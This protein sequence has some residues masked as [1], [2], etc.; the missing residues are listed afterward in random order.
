VSYEL[1]REGLVLERPLKIARIAAV[2]VLKQRTI[3]KEPF[4]GSRYFFLL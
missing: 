2:D 1:L 4:D 3:S